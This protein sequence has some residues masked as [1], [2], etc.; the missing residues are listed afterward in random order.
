MEERFN[1][2]ELRKFLAPE[3]IFGADARKLAGRYAKNL[4]G[5]FVLLVTDPGVMKA[6]WHNDIILALEKE[7]IHFIL[8]NN[9]TP[10]P[11][12][13]EVM[14]GA[15]VYKKN[16]CNAIVAIGGGSAMDCAKGIGIVST[17][18]QHILKFEG[19]DRVT[20]PMPPLVCIPTTAGSSAD[21][22]QFAI[23]NNTLDKVKIAI[24][25]K[26]VVPDVALIDP[27]T[28]TTM[29]SYLTA[30]TGID[31]LVHAIEAYVSNAS[32]HFT[33]LHALEAIRLISR[34]IV[35]SVN[36][37]HDLEIKSKMMIGSL[38]AGLAFSNASLGTVHAMAHSLG[39]FLNLPH[40]ECNAM[41]L[42]FVMDFNYSACPERY[43]RIGEALNIE[44][45]KLQNPQLKYAILHEINR[46]KELCGINNSL[47]QKG[48]GSSDIP[49]LAA[50]AI[51]DPCNATNPRK[52]NQRDLEVI[53]EEAM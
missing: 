2:H 47:S 8:Y 1:F 53:Y 50:K 48:V 38:E 49:I 43:E 27:V 45:G 3:F 40:G 24:I 14:D 29:D 28:L 10:N 12:M 25:S 35:D 31:A 51:R 33:D 17:N 37:Q 18:H 34:N 39:G 22:S 52:P 44:T 21:V 19:V 11:K 32:S 6:G 7:S 42:P 5:S 13:E 30:C 9:I 15:E 46:L 26:A 23:I 4:G 20:K 41:L 16:K 36:N